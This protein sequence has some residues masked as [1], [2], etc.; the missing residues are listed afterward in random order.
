MKIGD[1]AQR[2][3][4]SIQTIRYY[5]KEG[6]LSKPKRSEGNFRLYSSE[7]LEQLLF[8]KHC[9]ELDLTLEEVRQLLNLQK[10]PDACCDDV[11]TMV[12]ALIQQVDTRIKALRNLKSQLKL[13]RLN[14]G[15][16][17]AVK[18]CGILQGLKA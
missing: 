2:S 13:L 16:A 7:A 8:I 4:C 9:R 3:N 12:D 15:G 14:C 5:E 11:S 18:D 1:L 10:S 6:L 17:K